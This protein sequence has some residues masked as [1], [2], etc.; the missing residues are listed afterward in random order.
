VPEGEPLTRNGHPVRDL[1]LI[2]CVGSREIDGIHEPQADGQVNNYCSRICC[3]ASLHTAVELRQRFPELNLYEIYQ[4]IRTY[5]RGH[6]DIFR[7]AH[8]SMVRFLRYH[9]D[10]RPEVVAAPTGDT[11]PLLV[12]V[13]DY[14]TYGEEIEI[15][16]D[17]V[18]LAVGMMP[19]Q[20]DG[21]V[22]ML[23][24]SRGA[25]RFLLEVH[26]KLRPVEMAVRGIV[27][28]GTAQ[29][30][31]N[32][33]ESLSAASAAAAKVAALLGQG[34]VELPP[35]VARVDETKCNG[36]GACVEACKEEGAIALQTFNENGIEIKRAVVTPA[37]CTGCGACVGACPNRAIDV[38]AWT[39]A[40]YEAMVDAI[41]MDLPEFSEA[42][43]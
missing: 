38:Q 3:T 19:R 26:P 5:G 28:A 10:E 14:L 40:Q 23:K 12:R 43:K 27:L 25:D 20:I 9:G 4:D 39:L 16:V 36:T 22:N 29:G 21:L 42:E 11:H 17:M 31:M 35:F 24:V 15:P 37:N 6:E 33:T 1:A 7:H 18:V 30:P 34:R 13:K 41:G 32:I 2:H 8:A